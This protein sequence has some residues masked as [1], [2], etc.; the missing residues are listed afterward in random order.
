M[1]VSDSLFR[2]CTHVRINKSL[3]NRTATNYIYVTLSLQRDIATEV[4]KKQKN[5]VYSIR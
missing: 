2:E 4:F 3:L 5:T 1:T